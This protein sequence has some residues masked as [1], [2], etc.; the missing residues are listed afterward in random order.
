[1]DHPITIG[2][3]VQVAVWYSV[4]MVAIPALLFGIAAIVD[5]FTK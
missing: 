1:M 2:D 4:G 5:R 3:L